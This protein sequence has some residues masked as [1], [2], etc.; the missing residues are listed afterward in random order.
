MSRENDDGWIL[1]A[2]GGRFWPLD[3]R[4]E[5]V[6]IED[7]A[8]AL[9]NLCRFTGH[10]RRF[11]SVAEHSIIGSYHCR[12]P[13]RFLLHDA[14]EAYIGDWATPVKSQVYAVH[15]PLRYDVSSMRDVEKR[16]HAAIEN[17][18]SLPPM[19]ADEEAEVKRVDLVMLATEKRDLLP[20]TPWAWSHLP[21]GVE[22]LPRGALNKWYARAKESFLS[23]YYELRIEEGG[24][25]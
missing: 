13:L 10:S 1:T 20:A 12:Y 24:A 19:T 11:Y 8:H 14:A 25:A 5:D 15:S 4:P 9:S 18:L 21:A 3:P 23:R 7:I 16:I 17:A 22:S 2:S 6:R